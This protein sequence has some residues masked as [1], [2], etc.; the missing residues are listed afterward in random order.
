M[1][2]L[3]LEHVPGDPGLT[4]TEAAVCLGFDGSGAC[5]S[6]IAVELVERNQVG[7]SLPALSTEDAATIAGAALLTFVIAFGLRLILKQMGVS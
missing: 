5:S 3:I 6:W 2:R 7:G 4:E 1:P